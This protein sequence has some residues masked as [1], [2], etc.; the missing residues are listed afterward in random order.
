MSTRT[1][2]DLEQLFKLQKSEDRI[3]GDP[4]FP[5]QEKFVNDNSPLGAAL[6]NRRAGKSYSVGLKLFRKAYQFPNSSLLYLALTR[7]SA[8]RIMWRDVLRTIARIH[9]IEYDA[10]ETNLEMHLPNGSMIKIAGAD[11]SVREKEK[12][13]GS[14]YPYVAVDEAGS[15]GLGLKEL[16]YDILEPAVAD[17]RGTIDLIGTPT[18]YYG[19]FFCKI[20]Q[21]EEPGWSLH[22]WSS[23]D[24][25]YMKKLIE[26]RIRIM[27]LRDPQIVITPGFKRMWL[28][29]W[30]KDSDNFIYKF[31][32]IRNTV[33][34]LPKAEIDGQ[35]LGIDLGFND[36]TAFCL[37]RWYHHDPTLYAVKSWKKAEM[38]VD[39]VIHTV[40]QFID[41]YNI[42][43]I[44]IDN[45]SKQVVETI[46]QRFIFYDV[47]IHPAVK[48]D[49]HEYIGIMNSEYI[50]GKIKLLKGECDDYA[51][52]MENLI[53]D[54]AKIVVTEL[55]SCPN[56]ICDSGLY[57][58]RHSR[59]FR[60]APPEQEANPVDLMEQ[61]VEA[62]VL[63][64]ERQNRIEDVVTYYEGHYNEWNEPEDF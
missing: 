6:C 44:V 13:L 36:D 58:W 38:I 5:Q 16:V 18:A 50:T 49:K 30:V 24:N 52:E 11:A 12:F 23:L 43:V 2:I 54:P 60:A 8:K 33:E 10:N 25:P 51:E 4:A 53:K 15:F 64:A 32:R 3:F 63:K 48:S 34:T 28:G 35:V 46:K 37:M 47:I 17:Y 61:A 21:G 42:S 31:D 19:G 41:E 40:K 26:D 55:A 56:H 45:A 9:D 14:K 27:K 59:N 62:R 20:T 7:E 29:Q 1:E 57:A 22:Q 39:D